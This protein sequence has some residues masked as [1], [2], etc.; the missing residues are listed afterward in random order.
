MI[1]HHST[2]VQRSLTGQWPSA[3]DHGCP[4]KGACRGTFAMVNLAFGALTEQPLR[5]L[6]RRMGTIVRDLLAIKLAP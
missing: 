5:T 1:G 3:P 4:Q 6:G 2:R